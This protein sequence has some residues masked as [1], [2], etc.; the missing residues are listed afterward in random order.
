MP[1]RRKGQQDGIKILKSKVVNNSHRDCFRILG[2][3]DEKRKGHVWWKDITD[4]TGGE[5][6]CL[7]EGGE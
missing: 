5:V 7:R 6:R 4:I 2:T 1:H 3:A